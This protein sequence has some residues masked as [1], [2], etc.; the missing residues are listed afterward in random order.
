MEEWAAAGDWLNSFEILVTDS[1]A[2]G[3]QVTK[4]ETYTEMQILST[5]VSNMAWL[6]YHEDPEE[7]QCCK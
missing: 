2:G 5:F 4:W 6:W 3:V 1:T 7:W